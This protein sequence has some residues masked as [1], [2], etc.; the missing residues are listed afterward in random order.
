MPRRKPRKPRPKKE[1]HIPRGY[2]SHWEYELHQRLF[3][4]WRHHWETIDYVIKHKYEPDFVRKFDDEKV[5]LIEAKGRFWDFPEYSKY[6]H[7]KKALP[8]HIELVFF[9]QK[10]FAPMPGAKVRKDKTKRTH[11]EWAEAND[12]RWFSEDKLPEKDWINGEI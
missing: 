2:D 5:I 11:A 6:I 1:A 3:S 8:E 7:I 9:F 4:D 12:F 10:P